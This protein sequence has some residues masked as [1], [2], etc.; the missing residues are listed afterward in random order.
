MPSAN[1][2]STAVAIDESMIEGRY[3]PLA[4]NRPT[5]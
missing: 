5:S 2:L 4:D 1:R 3:A